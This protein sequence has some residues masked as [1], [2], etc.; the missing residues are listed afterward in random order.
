MLGSS[1]RPLQETY[2]VAV[3]DLDGVV[4]VGADA[5]P[6]APDALNAAQAGGMHLAFV[7][8]NAARPPDEIAGQL[9]D[10]GVD[11]HDE[12]VVTSSQAAARL[13]STQ[14]EP[15]SKVYLI[16]GPGLEQALDVGPGELDGD[17]RDSAEALQL[18]RLAGVLGN[19]VRYGTRGAAGLAEHD[20]R[21]RGQWIL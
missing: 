10:F 19:G 9:R 3:L 13:L 14:L 15:G 18:E 17:G 6:G 1:E 2:D 11:A 4:Y 5:V 20:H 7:T 8:N 21:D 16:G 12:D